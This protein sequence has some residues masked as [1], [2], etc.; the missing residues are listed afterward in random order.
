MSYEA[1]KMQN[2]YI[3]VFLYP[4]IFSFVPLVCMTVVFIGICCGNSLFGLLTSK[5]CRQLGQISYSI[6]LL[7]GL[8][9]FINFYFALGGGQAAQFTI[10]QHWIT[11]CICSIFVVILC[12]F[13]YY[14]IEKPGIESP[15]GLTR[16]IRGF[17]GRK[18]PNVPHT[19]SH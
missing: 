1:N 11:I 17:F 8:L 7:H 2:M 10:L 12:S 9:L 3:A 18:L 13:S 19:I 14:Y 16:K 4:L 5:P 6:Y 15:T